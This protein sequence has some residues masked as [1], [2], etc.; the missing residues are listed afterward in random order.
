[1]VTADGRGIGALAMA[2]F[3]STL[4]HRVLY[5]RVVRQG[6]AVI[7][8]LGP[9]LDRSRGRGDLGV[10]VRRVAVCKDRRCPHQPAWSEG[11]AALRGPVGAEQWFE[12]VEQG[13]GLVRGEPVEDE[14]ADGVDVTG[15]GLDDLAPAQLGQGCHG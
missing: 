4:D 9:Y 5:V 8:S 15:C 12:G 7:Q 13:A 6:A 2:Q 10:L 14:F 3:G 11:S 1:M